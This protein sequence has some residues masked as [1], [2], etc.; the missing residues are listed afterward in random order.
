MSGNDRRTALLGR[1]EKIRE[2]IASFFRA[3]TQDEVHHVCLREEPYSTVQLQSIRSGR[4]RLSDLHWTLHIAA[5]FRP[6]ER[7]EGRR[8]GGNQTGTIPMIG[9]E[10][11]TRASLCRQRSMEIGR[12]SVF[13][14]HPQSS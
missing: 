3:F 12:S 4:Q 11:D 8:Y 10:N 9:R 14:R 13:H 7:D 5:F 2:L 1:I 6:R